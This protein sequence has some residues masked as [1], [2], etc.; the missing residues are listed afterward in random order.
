MKKL[1]ALAGF[2][3]A[4]LSMH[5]E[6]RF[7]HPTDFALVPTTRPLLHPTDFA[8]IPTTRP[9]FFPGVPTVNPRAKLIAP[10]D[11]PLVPSATP[12]SRAN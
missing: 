5:A 1:I 3:A 11:F 6:P 4:A 12:D 10:T 9:L 7:L 8:L 2:L